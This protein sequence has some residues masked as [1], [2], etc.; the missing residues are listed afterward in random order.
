MPITP[1]TPSGSNAPNDLPSDAAGAV[2]VPN[3]LPSDAAG[4]VNTPNTL[5]SDAAGAVAVPNTLPADAAGALAV[6]NTLPSDAAG[7]VAVPNTLPADGAGSVAS[8][9]S[10]PSVAAAAAPRTLTPMVNLDFAAKSYARKGRTVLFD[11]LLTYTRPSSATFINRRPDVD[12]GYEYFLDTDYVGDVTNLA[13]HSEDFGNAVWAKSNTSITTSFITSPHGATTVSKLIENSASGVHVSSQEAVSVSAGNYNFSV[14]MKKA[15][16]R[17]GSIRAVSDSF[18][19]RFGAVIDLDTGIITST[20]NFG[21]AIVSN[22]KIKPLDNGW[23]NISVTLTHGAGNIDIAACSSDLPVP[24]FFG[25]APQYTGDGVSG[26]YIWGAQVT[27]SA[28]VLPYVK[29]LA[30]TATQTF[31]E[32]LRVEY[33]AATGENLGALIEGGSTNLALYSEQFGNAVWYNQN[34]TVVSNATEAPDNTASAY[35]IIETTASSTQFRT[36][37][38]ITTVI[39]NTY[40]LSCYFKY[41]GAEWV[42]LNFTVGKA[43]F[44]LKSGTVGTVSSGTASIS[45]EGNGWFKCS[46]SAVASLTGSTFF[47]QLSNADGVETYNG[48]GTSGVYVWGAQVE[49]LPFATSYIRTEGAAVSRSSDGLSIGAD[50]ISDQDSTFNINFKVLGA[51][52]TFQKIFSHTGNFGYYSLYTPP[53]GYVIQSTIGASSSGGYKTTSANEHN[54]ITGV[55]S[56][57]N[58]TFS[59]YSENEIVFTNSISTFTKNPANRLFIGA[60]GPTTQF[61]FGHISKFKTY[62]QALTAQEI[63]LL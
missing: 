4:A 50:N 13:L 22:L 59:G 52:T 20:S 41:S 3:T 57:L 55:Y 39:G 46:V 5:P 26:I 23:F 35:K 2:A 21:G 24:T 62:A 18:G 15:E 32:T 42:T 16:R 31:T 49:A 10:L 37:Q 54:K 51:N 40:T 48:D 19:K 45:A 30:S 8:P 36:R 58:G 38:V 29:T 33:D 44:N 56:F 27:A 53:S 7:A 17:Y 43:W 1:I 47:A 11:D 60:S 34:L 9:V 63:T 28:K 61:T 14:Y 6:P 12:G 25:A